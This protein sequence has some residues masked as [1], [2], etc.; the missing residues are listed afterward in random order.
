MGLEPTTSRFQTARACRCTTPRWW[1]RC[2]RRAG[3]SNPQTRLGHPLSR[4]APGTDAGRTLHVRAAE[5]EGVEPSRLIAAR[6]QDGR[7]RHVGLPF[8]VVHAVGRARIELASFGLR[9]RCKPAFATDPLGCWLDTPVCE[10]SS[11]QRTRVFVPDPGVEPGAR[12]SE[13]RVLPLDQSGS[14]AAEGSAQRFRSSDGALVAIPRN[15]KATEAP[16]GGFTSPLLYEQVT[17]VKRHLRGTC[18]GRRIVVRRRRRAL[19]ARYS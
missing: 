4:R 11:C 19:P 18:C 13:P 17:R 2:G 9:D 6:F 3:E 8:H 1:R 5:G 16:L 10:L 12:G 14:R 15:E 7:H